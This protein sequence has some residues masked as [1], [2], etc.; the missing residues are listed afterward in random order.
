[1]GCGAS[2]AGKVRMSGRARPE[3]IIQ[4]PDSPKLEAAVQKELTRRKEEKEAE[5]R[6]KSN[7]AMLLRE[8]QGCGLAE[9]VL[10]AMGSPVNT[11]ADEPDAALIRAK[12][13][14]DHAPLD[15]DDWGKTDHG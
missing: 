1:M 2:S 12:P 14:D 5:F 10:A 9:S 3:T 7:A 13:V 8:N 15:P 6:R 11:S 4:P